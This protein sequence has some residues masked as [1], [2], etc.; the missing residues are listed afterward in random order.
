MHRALCS[1]NSTEMNPGRRP[2][3]TAHNILNSCQIL[4]ISRI[5]KLVPL[6]IPLSRQQNFDLISRIT[7]THT[8]VSPHTWGRLCQE[9]F[10]SLE[11]HLQSFRPKAHFILHCVSK[12]GSLT[13]CLER[14]HQRKAWSSISL[15]YLTP[16][17][18]Q[19]AEQAYLISSCTEVIAYFRSPSC[20]CS[21]HIF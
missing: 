21:P 13:G 8:K 16:N 12:C 9:T 17:F 11:E 6:N 10:H 2:V 4:N 3:V 1:G 5:L 19:F 15:Q 7:R 18:Q 20:H 14:K